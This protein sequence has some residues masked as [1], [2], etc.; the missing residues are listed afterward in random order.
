MMKAIMKEE[1]EDIKRGMHMRSARM[2][3]IEGGLN[4]RINKD[5]DMR[6]GLNKKIEAAFRDMTDRLNKLETGGTARGP[7][8][9]TPREPSEGAHG[10]QASHIIIGGSLIVRADRHPEQTF[11]A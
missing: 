3:A 10:G 8:Q 11:S 4:D 9:P 7:T 5:A 2:T 1:G 6:E